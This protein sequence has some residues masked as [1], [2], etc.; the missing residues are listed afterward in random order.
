MNLLNLNSEELFSRSKNLAP[1]GVHSPVR[2]FRSVGGTPVFFKAADGAFLTSV[3]GT[4]YLD[5]CQSFGPLILGHRHPEVQKAITKML[6]TAWSFG[7]CEPYSLALGEKIKSW[8]PFVD[9]L[10]FVSSGTEAVMS[11]IRLSKAATGRKYV[12]K[13]N[14]C[15]HGHVDSMLV[16]SGSGLAGLASS[17]SAGVSAEIAAETLVAELDDEQAIEKLF[18]QYKNQIAALIVEPVPANYG[19]LI[20]RKEFLQFLR[21]ITKKHG[22]LLIFDEV[23]TGF[24]VGAK[25]LAGL[26]DITPDLVSYGKVLGGGLN[27]GCYG[28]RGDLMDLIAP[29]GP[30]Y[31]AGTLSAGPLAMAAGLATLEQI[32]QNQ[33]YT[34]LHSRVESFCKKLQVLFDQSG[35]PFQVSH[36]ESLFWIHGPSQTP[37]RNL[38]QIPARHKENF[39]VL[40]HELMKQGLY[41]AP[42][43]YEVG[44][45]SLAHDEQVLELALEK[46]AAA[47]AK[48]RL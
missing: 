34:V 38:N 8:V 18:A 43:G 4:E 17:D 2:A 19:L 26:W 22:T 47:L 13:F 37:I 30:V 9:K 14:G 40:F 28:G 33:V 44:F 1:G 10:R 20:Q 3:E 5:F 21:E 15:Y 48:V 23:I 36:F 39:A 29:N 6:D 31:Q 25:G 42:S 24:R 27:V 45:L 41:L 35:H 12:L 11:L 7:A 46:F 32:E 16:K